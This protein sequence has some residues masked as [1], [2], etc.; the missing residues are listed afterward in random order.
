MS[1]TSQERAHCNHRRRSESGSS[2]LSYCR[3]LSHQVT[4]IDKH[5][6]C[7]KTA[8]VLRDCRSAVDLMRKARILD[9]IAAEATPVPGHSQR[10]CGQHCRSQSRSAFR[11]PLRD[12]VR[13]ARAQ[14]PTSVDC[15]IDEVVDIQTS[16]QMQQVSLSSGGSVAADLIILA[17]GMADSLRHKLGIRRR[18]IAEKQSI[19][20]GFTLAPKTERAAAFSSAHLLRRG[21]FQPDRL[22]Q[23]LSDRQPP[24]RQPLFTF[25]DHDDP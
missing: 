2:P 1:A 15:I 7:T 17:T 4:L 5:K 21:R 20:F 16:P 10:S 14:L 3:G 6:T 12:I 19:S 9:A 8:F 22:S 23:P 11:H 24:A 18:I 13:I 25:L